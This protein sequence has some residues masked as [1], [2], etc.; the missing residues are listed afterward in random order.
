MCA[1]FASTSIDGT[2]AQ[3]VYTRLGMNGEH[4]QVFEWMK[5]F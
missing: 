4:Y 5:E 1:A 2:R 3:T